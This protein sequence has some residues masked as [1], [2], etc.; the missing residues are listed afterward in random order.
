MSELGDLDSSNVEARITGAF[1]RQLQESE[2]DFDIV[3]GI[4]SLIDEED[5]G[6]E[7]AVIELVEEVLID[8]GG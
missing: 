2:V 1:M 5:F 8:D 4:E 7:D 6:G 3:D